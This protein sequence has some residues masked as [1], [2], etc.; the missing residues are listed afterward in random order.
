MNRSTKRYLFFSYITYVYVSSCC[1]CQRKYVAQSQING[2][3]NETQTHSLTSEFKS[4]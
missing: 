2:V 1:F 4:Y 3:P